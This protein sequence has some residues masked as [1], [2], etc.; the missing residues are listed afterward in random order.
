MEN[1]KK[2]KRL[3]KHDC[4]ERLAGRFAANSA[5]FVPQRPSADE[6][7]FGTDDVYDILP[8]DITGKYYN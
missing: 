1:E 7:S 3:I 4:D 6:M 2:K 5:E 8:D